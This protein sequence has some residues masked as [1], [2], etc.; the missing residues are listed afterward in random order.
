[1]FCKKC[2]NPLQDGSRFCPKCGASMQNDTNPFVSPF[3]EENVGTSMQMPQEM[4][5]PEKRSRKTAWIAGISC[6][7]VL[8]LAAAGLIYAWRQCG[9]ICR[10]R[11]DNRK[12]EA[13]DD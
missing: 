4:A 5:V 10:K 3:P 12:E 2:G 6:A 11:T 7:C 1:M 13:D 9:G 8:L